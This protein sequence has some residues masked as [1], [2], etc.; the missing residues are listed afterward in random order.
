MINELKRRLLRNVQRSSPTSPVA[1]EHGPGSD[2]ERWHQIV[3]EAVEVI[4]CELDDVVGRE[5]LHEVSKLPER[6]PDA[7]LG[8]A[9]RGSPVH[10]GRVGSADDG[11]S[12][13]WIPCAK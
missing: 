3:E 10:Q 9:A 2:A 7:L 11:H 5:L 12:H 13:D 4:G 1:K 6:R 8:F